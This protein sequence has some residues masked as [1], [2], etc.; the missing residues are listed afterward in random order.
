MISL[1]PGVFQVALNKK[2]KLLITLE[3]IGFS[4]S[5][6][7]HSRYMVDIYLYIYIDVPRH[8]LVDTF[9]LFTLYLV[10]CV[11]CHIKLF[12]VYFRFFF[13]IFMH[14]QFIYTRWLLLFFCLQIYLLFIF[15]L[16]SVLNILF[17]FNSIFFFYIHYYILLFMHQCN[18]LK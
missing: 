6:Q 16:F 2:K 14:T 8:T 13:S 3:L 5:I 4:W 15:L 10:K 7:Q 11:H 9:L 12:P 1:L 17:H 18:Y